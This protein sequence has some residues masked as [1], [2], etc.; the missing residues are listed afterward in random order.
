M[1]PA[2]YAAQD[3]LGL[4]ELIASRQVSI[5][6]VARAARGAIA[7][8][9]PEVRAL[10]ELYEENLVTPDETAL[11]QGPFRGVPFAIKDVGE[12]FGGRRLEN[13]SRLCA[14]MVVAEDDSFARLVKAS[15][16]NL[17]ARSNTPEYSMALSAV[18]LLHGATSNPW[19]KDFST[20]GSSGGAAAA[21][22]SGMLPIAHASD[23][24]GSTRGPAAW[25]GTIGLQPS[26]GRVSAAPKEEHMLTQS[27]VVTRSMRDTAAMLDCL[28]KP[29]PSDGFVVPRPDR[30][31]AEFLGR[32]TRDIR[33]AFSTQPL[34]DAPVDP[35]IAEGVRQV[36]SVLEQR[37][38]AVEEAAPEYDSD[39]ADRSCLHT[40]FFDF[41]TYL[42]G[43]GR[44]MGRK[45]G[46]DTVENATLRFYEFSRQQPVSRY[47]QAL[48]DLQALR[49]MIGPF[50]AKYDVWLSPTT[51]QVAEHN[52]R[53]S[54]NIG[55]DVETFITHENR[56]CQFMIPYNIMGRPALSLPTGMHSSGLPFGVQLGARHGEEHLL[57]EL[58]GALEQEMP[59]QQRHPPLHVANRC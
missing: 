33:I 29:Q 8:I 21:V 1:K 59:W 19:K 53:Y 27:F 4:A 49:R 40:W 11:G 10:I 48:D 22:A 43:L 2:E 18:N 41:H 32:R 47:F 46:S 44:R 42:D 58:G 52:D 3:G 56:P 20:S 25:C 38:Y 54:M 30:P 24:G 9:N 31:F 28:G 23:M 39:L 5:G 34:M 15:G 37:G 17:V 12:H 55:V 16:V 14:G 57:I 45:V 36:A 7:A 35:E 6:E 26:R 51:A 50:F 13:G